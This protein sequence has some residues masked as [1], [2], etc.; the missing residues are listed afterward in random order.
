ME[1]NMFSIPN[2]IHI[3]LMKLPLSE[4]RST[5]DAAGGSLEECTNI[6][7]TLEG[8]ESML[9]SDDVGNHILLLLWVRAARRKCYSTPPHPEVQMKK[10]KY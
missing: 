3:I 7:F 8:L 10:I 2:E 9:G 4:L 1:V 6:V 5:M